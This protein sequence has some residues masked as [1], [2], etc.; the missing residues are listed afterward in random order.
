ML[1]LL[2]L[3]AA[4]QIELSVYTGYQTAPHSDVSGSDPGGVGDFDFNAEW[5]GKSFDIPPYYG[6]RA[7]WW[8]T[9]RFGLGLE[10]NHAKVYASD[11][12]LADNGFD[13]LELTDGHNLVTL[14]A[15]YRWPQPDRR[16]TPYVGGGLG[17]AIP[18]ADVMTAGGKTFEYQLTGAAVVWIAGLSYELNEE[19]AIFGEYKG[20]Y[21]QNDIDLD[22][23][24]SMDA[25][26]VTNALNIGISYRF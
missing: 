14:N 10:F 12:T 3:P 7:T 19:W 21:S 1:P 8:R 25:N 22:N 24:G 18:H 11:D 5:K 15:F 2:A 9:E 13:R 23:G 26:I 4:A 17:V 6:I 20:S 16:W